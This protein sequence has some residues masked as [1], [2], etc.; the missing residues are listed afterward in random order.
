MS[1]DKRHKGDKMSRKE[2]TKQL[3]S[4]L[5]G[6]ALSSML[7]GERYADGRK[8]DPKKRP[9][10]VF[11]VVEQYCFKYVGY[12][13]HNF[14]QTPNLDRIAEQGV[15]FNNAYTTSPVCAPA[16]TGLMT[17][18]FP[19]DNNS[20]GNTTVWDGSHP[21][22]GT[23]LQKAGYDTWATGKMD[24]N[25]AFDLGFKLDY[26]SNGHEGH[27]DVGELFREP[28]M[29]LLNERLMVDGKSRKQRY[30][31]DVKAC[32]RA[33]RHL[34]RKKKS[35]APW[36]T[37][38]GYTLVH[39]PFIA[40]DKYYRW[41]YPDRV[42]MPNIPPGHLQRLH[43]MFQ[44]LRTYK[45]LATPIFPK[46]RIRRARAGYFGMIRE[47]DEYVGRVWNQ[48]EK[49]GQL[50]N[51]VFV[52]TADHGEMLG[53]HGLWYKNN[54]YEE[55]AHIP[56]LIAGA[57]LSKGKQIK[58]P[59]SH[60]DLV[61]TLLEWTGANRPE[62]LRGHSL[63]S[64]INGDGLGDHPGYAYAE[65]H[66]EGNCTGSFMIRKGDWKYLNFTWY[67]DLLFNLS[68]DPGEFTNRIDDP[69]TEEVQVELKNILHSLVDPKGV[70]KRAFRVQQKI[71]DSVVRRREADELVKFLNKGGLNKKGRLGPGQ[72]KALA[73]ELKMRRNI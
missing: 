60:V 24:L 68:E 53:A 12:T 8:D 40:L 56:L 28:M 20:F 41:F 36:A 26:V 2:F 73:N 50:D 51:T 44:R 45:R 59:V 25:T 15:R 14:V 62:S 70:T 48:V 43:L 34:R 61:Y 37:Y 29:Y 47:L 32:N 19:S 42:D 38:I 57:G 52:F 6:A 65:S 18:T 23:L 35:K 54:L 27:G 66:S 11:I 49:M 58:T 17:G 31:H 64:M 46:E 5:G 30:R 39:S 55:A 69:S 9:N 33:V 1:Y 21:T 22:W 7:P 16:R 72:A 13:G 67:D 71:L 63:T 4:G 3:S 10:I